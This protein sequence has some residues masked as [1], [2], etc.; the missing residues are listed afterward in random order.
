M[1]SRRIVVLVENI[2][3]RDDLVAE[4]GLSVWIEANG[5]RF[6]FDTGQGGAL[7]R[8]AEALGIALKSADAVLLSHG[9][10]DHTG[11]LAHVLDRQDPPALHIHPAAVEPKYSRGAGGPVRDVGMPL[12]VRDFVRSAPGLRWTVGPTEVCPGLF[13]TGPVPRRNSFEDTGGPFFSD[14]QCRVPDA[15]TDDQAA[16]MDTPEG[17]VVVLGCAHSGVINTLR[18]IRDLGW[19][20]PIRAV[21]G[22]MHLLNAGRERMDRTAEA[23]KEFEIGQLF[24]AHCT[25]R[26]ATGRLSREFPGQCHPFSSGTVLEL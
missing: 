18:Y 25:G 6:L 21:M 9:H 23:L 7:V 13:L 22:G 17:L 4:H 26:E 16:F 1:S 11:G 2:A 5:L 24:P 3:S 12:K 14:E 10:Y 8:N 19:R 15:L 20:A